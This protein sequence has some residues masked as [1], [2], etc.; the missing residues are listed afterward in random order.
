MKGQID[1]LFGPDG[2]VHAAPS[3]TSDVGER[4]K[5]RMRKQPESIDT[6]E[7]IDACLSCTLPA[8]RCE[9]GARC[10]IKRGKTRRG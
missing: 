5:T 4:A 8:R 1:S 9:G 7:M 3:V 6:P 2:L 10:P